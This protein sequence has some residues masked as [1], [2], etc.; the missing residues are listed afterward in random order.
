MSVADKAVEWAVGIANDNSH[1]YDQ[2][3]RWGKDYDCSSLVISAYENAGVP[4][5]SY[6]ATYTGNMRNVF[7]KCGFYEVTDGTLKPGD[8]LLNE[9]RHTAMYIGNGQIVQAS[10]NEKGTTTGG[11]S[12]DQTGREISTGAYY[13]PSYGWDCVLRYGG[14]ETPSGGA[15]TPATNGITLPMLSYGSIGSAVKTAQVLLINK[16]NISCGIFGADAD[17]GNAT[18]KAVI[19]F[20]ESQSIDADGV[21]GNITWQKLLE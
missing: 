9:A 1:G 11:A 8:V 15:S 16:F 17:F 7:K 3:S 5:K 21:I 14:A 20:Q 12:G 10:I 4:V 19:K 2:A 18:K 6:G 13:V